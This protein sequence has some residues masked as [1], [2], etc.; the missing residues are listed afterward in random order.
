[1]PVTINCQHCGKPFPVK[2]SQTWIKYCSKACR[3][4]ATSVEKSP[5]VDINCLVCG[6]SFRILKSDYDRGQRCCSANCASQKRRTKTETV[7]K[8]CGKVFLRH[9]YNAG[10]QYCSNECKYAHMRG[11]KQA[12]KRAYVRRVE[13]VETTCRTCGKPISVT[14]KK[15]ERGQ[16]RYCSHECQW[17]NQKGKPVPVHPPKT[18]IEVNCQQCGKAFEA[19]PSTIKKGGAKYCSVE[20]RNLSMRG[21]PSCRNGKRTVIRYCRE[22]G[23]DTGR[24]DRVYCS[25]ECAHKNHW[26]TKTCEHCGKEFETRPAYIKRG[27]GRFCSHSCAALHRTQ[28]HHY[29]NPTDIEQLLMNEMDQ[30][31]LDYEF[32]YP[33]DSMIVDFAFPVERLCIEAD[34]EYWHGRPDAI[35]RDER[36]NWFIQRRGWFVLRFSGSQIHESPE[37][38]VDTIERVLYDLRTPMHDY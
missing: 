25:K 3:S 18:S 2:P 37:D 26:I 36:R 22:C 27:A 33:F 35:E 8:H 16:G 5:R 17:A 31:G 24:S 12:H 32:Q 30:R 1:M 7:C 19:I 4:A 11:R 38:C 6:K 13:Y 9:E 10:R 21:K 34:G 15:W 20:C 14:K 29:E 28:N 23:K